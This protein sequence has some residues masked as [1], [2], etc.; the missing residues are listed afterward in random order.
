VSESIENSVQGEPFWK[1]HVLTAEKFM[2]T[3]QEYCRRNGL[4]PVT[5]SSYKVK[6]GFSKRPRPR[7]K[8]FVKVEPKAAAV[9]TGTLGG[10]VTSQK[11]RVLPDAKWTAELISALMSQK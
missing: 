10:Q 7:V 3:D 4:N 1:E 11:A 5:F 9:M 6:L 2:G 8:A